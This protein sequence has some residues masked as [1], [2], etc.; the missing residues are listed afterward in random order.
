[1][2]EDTLAKAMR[3][4]TQTGSAAGNLQKEQ[5]Q[6][7]K[8]K[9][10]DIAS[11]CQNELLDAISQSSIFSTR[12][13]QTPIVREEEY[14]GGADLVCDVQ[15]IGEGHDFLLILG[16]PVTLNSFG[17][18]VPTHASGPMTYKLRRISNGA[19]VEDP[20]SGSWQLGGKFALNK[21][22]FIMQLESAIK[23]LFGAP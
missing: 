23:R 12:R 2:S 18:G 6:A 4:A 3:E 10:V 1:M 20:I 11:V 21:D 19:E 22:A 15:V 8:D 17:Q 7:A 16:G 5:L 13:T 14:I 9:L